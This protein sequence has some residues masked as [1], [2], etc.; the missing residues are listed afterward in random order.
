MEGKFKGMV[1]CKIYDDSCGRNGWGGVV[2][3]DT[4]DR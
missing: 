1:L 4:I 2:G 3:V